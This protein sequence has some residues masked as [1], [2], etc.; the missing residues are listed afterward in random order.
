MSAD[1]RGPTGASTLLDLLN[2]ARDAGFA[3]QFVAAPD[4]RV[5]CGDCDSAV[6]ADRLVVDHHDRLEGASDAA[7]MMLVVRGRCPVCGARGVLTLG[8][9][10]NATADDDAVMERLSPDPAPSSSP[11]SAADGPDTASPMHILIA[12]DGTDESRAAATT[13]FEMFGSGHEYTIMSVAEIQPVVVSGYGIGSAYTSTELIDR[14]DAA[15][16][17][18]AERVADLADA[19]AAGIAE[20]VHDS[21]DPGVSICTTAEEIDADLVVIGSHEH[22]FWSR[23]LDPSVGRYVTEHAP[24]PVLVVR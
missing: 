22:G 5:R 3:E 2:R 11:R 15:A 23:L 18:T 24:C 21:G 16:Q 14:I 19:S 13:A 17:R 10:P 20:A 1:D 12:V 9:G 4:G 8:Y 7:D 6:A